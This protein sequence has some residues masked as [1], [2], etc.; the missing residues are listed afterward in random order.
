MVR[1]LI[2][3]ATYFTNLWEGLWNYS[4]SWYF[5]QYT[6]TLPK[7]HP[8]HCFWRRSPSETGICSQADWCGRRLRKGLP[9]PLGSLPHSLM[10]SLFLQTPLRIQQWNQPTRREIRKQKRPPQASATTPV[11]AATRA[12][13]ENDWSSGDGNFHLWCQTYLLSLKS[14]S[15]TCLKWNEASSPKLRTTSVC[16]RERKVFSDYNTDQGESDGLLHK[17]YPFTT[18]LYK[19]RTASS[20][21]ITW[22]HSS[23][24]AGNHYH[25]MITKNNI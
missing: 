25:S 24:I 14:F 16:L 9:P 18:H 22:L 6:C 10:H 1:D 20:L 21:F 11:T 3:P 15:K 5:Y 2:L 13:G 4:T 23:S 19:P 17:A 12:Q 7:I 8:D